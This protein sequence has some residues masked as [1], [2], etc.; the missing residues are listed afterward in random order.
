MPRNHNKVMKG[1]ESTLEDFVLFDDNQVLKRDS[2]Q[3]RL[4][5]KT[6]AEVLKDVE[7]E[8]KRITELS[9]KQLQA[10][11]TLLNGDVLEIPL[12]IKD[13]VGVKKIELVVE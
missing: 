12:G 9:T 3:A 2:S 10:V 1:Q 13:L 7:E 4:K 6:D 5:V 8:N 11:I